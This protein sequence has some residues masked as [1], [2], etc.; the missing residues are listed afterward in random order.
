MSK[1]DRLRVAAGQTSGGCEIRTREGLPPT[2]FPTMLTSVHQGPPPSVT[3]LN[4]TGAVAGERR[5]TE[6]NETETETGGRAPPP[7][8]SASR[9][10]GAPVSVEA[11]SWRS[12][13]PLSRPTGPGSRPAP[14]NLCSSAWRITPARTARARSCRWPRWSATPGCRS[15]RYAP[16]W[17]GWKAKAS[18]RRAIPT[19]SRPGSSEP[20]GAR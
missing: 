12:I 1:I 20:T 4:M 2:R 10:S 5:R 19:L 8:G 15:G 16:A 9:E 3:C 13:W 18:S 17:S 7:R 11:I 6:V 14:A